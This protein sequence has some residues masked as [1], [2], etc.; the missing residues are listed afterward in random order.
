[1]EIVCSYREQARSFIWKWLSIAWR[2]INTQ[3]HCFPLLLREKEW[4]SGRGLDGLSA[5]PTSL[6]TWIWIPRTHM[7]GRL[8]STG[9]HNPSAL[10][11]RWEA[12]TGKCLEAHRTAWH[13]GSQQRPRNHVPSKAEG[14]DY[15]PRSSS[16]LQVHHD[17]HASHTHAHTQEWSHSK[18]YDDYWPSK[19]IE[20][21]FEYFICEY[22][23]KM[24]QKRG[25]TYW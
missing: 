22:M 11:R 10:M 23:I 8:S 19:V 2:F 24:H 3:N 16:T 17:T 1:M 25:N 5:C 13:T 21:L 12:D 14:K 20:D 4:G 18:L 15:H 9:I 7:K 6:M